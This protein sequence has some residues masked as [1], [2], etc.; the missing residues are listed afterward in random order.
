MELL[1]ALA[2]TSVV[3]TAIFLMYRVQTRSH[4]DQQVVVQMQQNMRAAMYL[5]EREIRMAGYSAANPPAQA[6]F[7]ENF[8]AFGEPAG[9]GFPKTDE[10]EIAFTVDNDDDGVLTAANSM[11]LIA[12][13]LD[14]ANNELQRWDAA[15]DSWQVAA[16]QVT[17]LEFSY[18]DGNGDPI[19]FPITAADMTEIESIEVDISITADGQELRE[20]EFTNRI[21]CRNMGL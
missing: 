9:A 7:V 11:E 5:L 13:R 20:M 10:D 14:A 19:P 6:G 1:V 3:M 12:Y 4:R 18:I 16:E 8:A 21:K 2:I 17:N 15:S